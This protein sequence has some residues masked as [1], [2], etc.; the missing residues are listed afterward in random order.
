[1]ISR[2][3]PSSPPV[4]PA[5]VSSWRRPNPRGACRHPC[6][7][8]FSSPCLVNLPSVRPRFR[9]PGLARTV[10][11]LPSPLHVS[12]GKATRPGSRVEGTHSRRANVTASRM[13]VGERIRSVGPPETP[14]VLDASK[15]P[16]SQHLELFAALAAPFEN[17]EVRNRQQGGRQLQYITA[18]TVM[19][20]L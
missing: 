4:M 6:S 7:V 10:F 16:M 19:N 12:L 2:P 17:D 9:D 13:A 15:S 11:S 14:L 1:M 8:E 18:R 5:I 20:R 3:T